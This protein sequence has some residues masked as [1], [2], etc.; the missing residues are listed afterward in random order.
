MQKS[1]KERIV[2]KAKEVKEAGSGKENQFEKNKEYFT[3]CIYAFCLV[4][5]S[6][7]AIFAIV[8]IDDTRNAIGGFLQ[9]ILPFLLGLIITYLIYPFM[10]KIDQL[11]KK[12]VMKKPKLRGLRKTL[13][14]IIA[15]AFILG[16]LITAMLYVIPQIIRSIQDLTLRLPYMYDQVEKFIQGLDENPTFSRAFANVDF[17]YIQEKISELEPEIYD[18]FKN[19]AADL[20]PILWNLSY[21]AV[22]ALITFTLTIVISCYMMFDKGN[23]LKG[24]KR[25]LYALLSKERADAVCV[26]GR[27]C[28]RIFSRF[29]IGSAT[30]SL[31]MGLM[32]FIFTTIFQLPYTVLISVI[33]GITNV[34]PY[35]GPF[36]GAAPG[37][38]IYLLIDP[39]SAIIFGIIIF[40]LQ[41]FDG[42]F[43]APKILGESTGLKPLWVIFAITVGGAYFGIV[44]MF[45]GVP[46]TA[47]MAYLVQAFIR[48]RLK[49]KG[50][51]NL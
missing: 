38:A 31:A 36:I 3:I 49:K 18:Y 20:V 28:S 51:A 4:V 2:A 6:T 48:T 7:V 26:I 21:G 13:S 14:I 42:L 33:V 8:N 32:C 24:F 1:S 44:G 25:F 39:K 19:F 5:A 37:I 47:V 16:L 34:I 41:Q 29:L 40:L 17:D 27:D 46:V 45:L 43:L 23:S 11:L 10:M 30:D 35:F 12:F 15:Y 9:S 22:R 50:I